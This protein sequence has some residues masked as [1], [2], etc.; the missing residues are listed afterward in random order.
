MS[1][2]WES[3]QF[4]SSHRGELLDWETSFLLIGDDLGYTGDIVVE[5]EQRGT[6]HLTEASSRWGGAMSAAAIWLVSHAPNE[7]RSAV[8]FGCCCRDHFCP[9]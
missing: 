3:S 5:V 8:C 9:S 1:T 4:G 2:V 6:G 7:V